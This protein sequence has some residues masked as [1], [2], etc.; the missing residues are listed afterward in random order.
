M[1]P[2]LTAMDEDQAYRAMNLLVGAGAQP[3]VLEAVF[4][5]V[6]DLLNLDVNVLFFRHHQLFRG[7]PV[8]QR[9]VVCLPGPLGLMGAGGVGWPGHRPQGRPGLWCWL[10]VASTVRAPRPVRAREVCGGGG[11]HGRG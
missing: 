4:F 7:G 10:S 5:A 3:G 6:A 1:I 9:S 2:G 8:L 11:R